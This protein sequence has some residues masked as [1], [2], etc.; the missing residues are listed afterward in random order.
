MDRLCGG[1]YK[2][3][4]KFE[5]YDRE[6]IG[7]SHFVGSCQATLEQLLATPSLELKDAKNKHVGTMNVRKANLL[8]DYTM[9]EYIAGGCEVSM[10][11]AIDFTGS[12]KGLLFYLKKL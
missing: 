5:V 1:D 4:L 10:I 7:K 8:K 3:P 2:R 9:L 11:V 6:M 12:I